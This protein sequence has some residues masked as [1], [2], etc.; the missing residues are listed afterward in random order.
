MLR[1]AVIVTSWKCMVMG[2]AKKGYELTINGFHK[3]ID[4]VAKVFQRH[5]DKCLS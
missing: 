2:D 1:Y 5:R 4:A 3:I